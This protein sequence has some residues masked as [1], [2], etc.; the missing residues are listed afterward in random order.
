MMETITLFKIAIAA[1]LLLLSY[2]KTIQ[3]KQKQQSVH[4]MFLK[5]KIK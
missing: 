4:E 2:R 1:G 3:I 5:C